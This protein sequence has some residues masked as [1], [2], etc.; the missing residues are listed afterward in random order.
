MN[1]FTD[2]TDFTNELDRANKF[3]KVTVSHTWQQLLAQQ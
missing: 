1:N 2:F 3:N